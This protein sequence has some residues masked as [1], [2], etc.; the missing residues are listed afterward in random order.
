MER[1]QQSAWTREG[2]LL[3]G[4]RGAGQNV[5][6]GLHTLAANERLD[7]GRIEGQHLAPVMPVAQD[8]RAALPLKPEIVGA[9]QA[10]P[11]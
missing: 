6:W 1:R 4:N 8:E 9:G 5:A 11:R 10:R 3:G 2:E 7:L